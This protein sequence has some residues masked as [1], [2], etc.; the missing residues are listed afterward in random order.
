MSK[1]KQDKKPELT[2][3][4][5]LKKYKELVAVHNKVLDMIEKSSLEIVLF[6]KKNQINLQ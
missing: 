1:K 3:D 5:L 4:E 2:F 6:C